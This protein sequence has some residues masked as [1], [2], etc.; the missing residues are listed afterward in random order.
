MLKC[1]KQ[2][3]KVP[4]ISYFHVISF[5]IWFYSEFEIASASQ[6]INIDPRV[7]NSLKNNIAL[8]IIFSL[9]FVLLHLTF[10]HLLQIVG[11][12]IN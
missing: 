3:A 5:M 8:F 11:V 2:N 6:T 4:V 9:C 7:A 1:D 10:Y 12:F